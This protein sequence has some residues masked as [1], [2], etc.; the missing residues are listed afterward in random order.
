MAGCFVQLQLRKWNCKLAPVPGTLLWAD[1]FPEQL[2][3]FCCRKV[4]Q[5]NAIEIFAA[6]G[7]NN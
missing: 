6:F 7:T 3:V 1:F 5:H 4:W 2:S